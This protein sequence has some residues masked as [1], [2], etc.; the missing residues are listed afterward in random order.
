MLGVGFADG[1]E[2]H[3]AV[4]ADEYVVDLDGGAHLRAQRVGVGLGEGLSFEVDDR[5][6]EGFDLGGG[7]VRETAFKDESD[8]AA[9]GD[10][11][12]RGKLHVIEGDVAEEAMLRVR[13]AVEVDDDAVGAEAE[14]GDLDAV[15]GSGGCA[16]LVEHAPVVF[17]V[18]RHVAVGQKGDAGAERKIAMG[19]SLL[20]L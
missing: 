7:D 10:R 12:L 3:L 5:V 15:S 17:V 19:E 20:G 2:D 6:E 8:A 16:F 9:G 11:A 4:H 18:R 1:G 13:A 14:G